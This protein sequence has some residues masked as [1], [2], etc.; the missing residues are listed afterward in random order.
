M[1]PRRKALQTAWEVATVKITFARCLSIVLALSAFGL[2][3]ARAAD[4]FVRFKVLEPPGEKFRVN[5]GGFIHVPNWYLSGE[6]VEVAGGQWSR[7]LDLR[8]WPLHG[9]LDREGGLAE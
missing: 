3:A 2:G 6:S 1:P 7:W 8:K 5:A 4:V 9:R